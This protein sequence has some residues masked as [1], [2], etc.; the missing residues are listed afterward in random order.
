MTTPSAIDSQ[1][2]MAPRLGAERPL[3][4]PKRTVRALKSGMQVVL[5]E[6]HAFPKISAQLAFR[7]GNAVAAHCS[8]G[9][10]EMTATVVRTGTASRSS[11]RI[12]EDLRRMGANLVTTAGADT[13]AISVSG[14]A[15]FSNG[16]LEL[17]A[18]LARN[19][20]FPED[21]FERERRQKIEELRVERATPGFLASERMRR[22]LFGEHPYAIVSPSP[23]DVAAYKREDLE[24]FYR[25]NYVPSHALFIVV[26]DFETAAM[27]EEIERVFGGWSAEEPESPEELPPPHYSGRHVHLVH[28]PGSVQTQLLVANLA[29]T[30]RDPDWYRLVLANSIYGGAFHSRLVANIREQK[31]YTYSPRSGLSALRHYGYF[32]VHA[33]VRHEVVA[34]TLTEIFYELDRI[35]SLPVT[36]EELDGARSYLSGVFSLGV[37]TQDG[38][39]GQLSTIYLDRLPE[40]YLETYRARIHALTADDV[41]AAARRHFDSPNAQI[42]VVGDRGQIADQAAV[43]G[44][45]ET[46]DA[47]GNQA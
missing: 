25:E 42:I 31:G 38:L 32:T 37:A 29:I 19:A 41:L 10:A 40:D 12:E 23:E 47:Q 44:D 6:S 26:G 22:V 27:L 16:L 2:K 13:S 18:D 28:L 45:V 24:K 8:P 3:A 21:E 11:R 4:W 43:F 5:A 46:F 30:R 17:M 14:L 9:L 1:N 34:A 33:A 39:L 35:R 7:S 15:E 36:P 20:S